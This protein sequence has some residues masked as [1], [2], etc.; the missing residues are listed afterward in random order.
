MEVAHQEGWE[1]NLIHGFVAPG[2]ESVKKEF[3]Q[4]FR[5]RG[6]LGAAVCIIYKGEKVV[7]LWGGYRDRKIKSPW[8]KDTLCHLFSATKA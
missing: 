5:C 4:N 3:V 2:W 8:Q 1:D 6:E 7:D